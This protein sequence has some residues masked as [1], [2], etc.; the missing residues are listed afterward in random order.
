[1]RGVHY[2]LGAARAL[3]MLLVADD[4][5][6]IGTHAD[7][8]GILCRSIGLLAGHGFPA[9]LEKDS[10]RDLLEMG[11]LRASVKR[12]CSGHKRDKVHATPP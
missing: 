10:G 2:L 1:M 7:F 9:L 8:L 3:W 5:A 11:G 6:M 12:S 4:L